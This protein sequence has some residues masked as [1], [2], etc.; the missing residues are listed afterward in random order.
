MGGG[1]GLELSGEGV[2]VDFGVVAAVGG[3]VADGYDF[4]DDVFVEQA[5]ERV[6]G[7]VGVEGVVGG[8]FDD[9]HAA[10]VE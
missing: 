1:R 10:A 4:I 7:V 3:D 8:R 6:V 5:G 2:V 9:E